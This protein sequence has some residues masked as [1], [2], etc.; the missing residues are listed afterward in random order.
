LKKNDGQI[1]A[2]ISNE[3]RSTGANETAVRVVTV[4]WSVAFGGARIKRTYT[5]LELWSECVAVPKTWI[6]KGNLLH[7]CLS[8]LCQDFS[9]T[10]GQ[11]RM[12]EGGEGI[13]LWRA[14][15]DT[16]SRNKKKVR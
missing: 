11:R 1:R 9:R 6:I 16:R 4:G 3:N 14:T 8:R 13:R 7:T 12:S 2:C 15:N 5:K 10:D